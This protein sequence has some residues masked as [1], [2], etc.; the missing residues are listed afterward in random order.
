MALNNKM[1]NMQC[2][3][4]NKMINMHCTDILLI[5]L[6]LLVLLFYVSDKDENKVVGVLISLV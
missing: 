5:F 3:L 4:N 6:L 2:T 1:I